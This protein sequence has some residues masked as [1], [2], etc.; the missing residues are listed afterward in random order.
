MGSSKTIL[1][2][3]YRLSHTVRGKKPAK[4]FLLSFHEFLSDLLHIYRVNRWGL[5]VF[6]GTQKFR[7]L[8]H[9]LNIFIKTWISN[10]LKMSIF[11]GVMSKIEFGQNWRYGYV[12]YYGFGSKLVIPNFPQHFLIIIGRIGR[13]IKK[14]KKSFFQK[15]RDFFGRKSAW[16]GSELVQ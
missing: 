4:V 16:K 9:K 6:L 3:L 5:E 1:P 10:F 12:L 8:T 14:S 7:I 11:G 2:I 15:K 13:F